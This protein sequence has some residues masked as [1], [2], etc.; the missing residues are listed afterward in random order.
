MTETITPDR[1]AEAQVT[2]ERRKHPRDVFVEFR[3]VF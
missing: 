1:K 3:N 2:P